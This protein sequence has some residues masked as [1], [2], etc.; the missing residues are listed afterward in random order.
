MDTINASEI[1][2]KLSQVE[3]LTDGVQESVKR[4]MRNVDWSITG[5]RVL[6]SC[7][8]LP[9]VKIA[10]GVKVYQFS[11]NHTVILRIPWSERTK[12]RHLY[13]GVFPA[14]VSRTSVIENNTC[15]GER[16][17]LLLKIYKFKRGASKVELHFYR[18]TFEGD[19]A[20]RC[21]VKM[22]TSERYREPDYFRYSRDESLTLVCPI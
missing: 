7:G 21:E 18:E 5:H 15:R 2:Q 17:P 14:E 6:A 3:L 20:D 10:T 9:L 1:A 13:G 12:A 19:R 11:G 22:V 8:F 16:K 4:L